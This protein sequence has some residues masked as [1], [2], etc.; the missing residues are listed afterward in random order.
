MLPRL[1]F[2]DDRPTFALL[3]VGETHYPYATPDEDV[4][5]WPVISGLH[6]VVKRLGASASTPASPDV[7]FDDA[8]MAQLRDRQVVAAEYCDGVLGQL[9][10]LVPDDTWMVVLSDHGELFGED[11][12]FGHGPIAHEK[13]L[14][15]PFVEGRVPR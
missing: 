3:N 2:A 15:V 13:V 6:G 8:Q 14:E 9:F 12:Y 10:D 4:S 7:F 1:A 5:E 11:G